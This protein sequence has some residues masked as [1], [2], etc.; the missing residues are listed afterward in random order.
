MNTMTASDKASSL[1]GIDD[2]RQR[3]GKVIIAF[4]WL[5]VVAIAITAA[6]TGKNLLI[7]IGLSAILVAVPTLSYAK[8]NIAPITRYLSTAA[9]AGLVA[10]LV[11][12]AGGTT[13]QIDMH[14]YFFAALAIA[15]TWCDWR[16][17]LI[18][19][20]IVAVHHLTLNFAYPYA[21][22]PDGADF[23][24]VVLHA[25]IVVIQTGF[26]ISLAVW[27]NSAV[28]K[29]EEA[30]AAADAAQ[31]DARQS[32]DNL[33]ALLSSRN[34]AEARSTNLIESF[35]AEVSRQLDA[36]RSAATTLSDVAGSLSGASSMAENKIGDVSRSA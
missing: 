34:S 4:L 21:V 7:F 24:R 36:V 8:E 20:G 19:S 27:L 6:L 5:N 10:V 23:G 2:L 30:R 22:F 35:R 33:E 14:M 3:L 13:Y 9:L 15:A 32:T 28:R 31:N 25:V 12:A 11:A 17:I 29:S 16:A 1:Q 18:Y 26:L